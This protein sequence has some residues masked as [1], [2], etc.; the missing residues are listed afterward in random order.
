MVFYALYPRVPLLEQ[1]FH[2]AWHGFATKSFYTMGTKLQSHGQC[3]DKVSHILIGLSRCWGMRRLSSGFPPSIWLCR[4]RRSKWL[5]WGNPPSPSW[6]GDLLV[7]HI[8]MPISH[9][10]SPR[11]WWWVSRGCVQLLESDLLAEILHEL[12]QLIICKIPKVCL[13]LVQDHPTWVKVAR[14]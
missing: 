12:L 10:I 2:F 7:I 14:G 6:K 1:H 3:V 8:R 4:G 9:R 13:Q 5:L 11:C